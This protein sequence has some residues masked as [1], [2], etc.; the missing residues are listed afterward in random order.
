MLYLFFCLSTGFRPDTPLRS[1]WPA[2]LYA[3]SYGIYDIIKLLIEHKASVNKKTGTYK[4]ILFYCKIENN[5]I[6]PRNE[7]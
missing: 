2:L 3:S 4:C 6:N 7:K 5:Y 1:G